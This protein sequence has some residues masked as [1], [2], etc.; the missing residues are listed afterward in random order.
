MGR[1]LSGFSR[2]TPERSLCSLGRA[3]ARPYNE[4]TLV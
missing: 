1:W 2:E 4:V 3:K